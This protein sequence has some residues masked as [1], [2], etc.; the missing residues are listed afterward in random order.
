MTTGVGRRGFV[1]SAALGMAAALAGAPA[2]AENPPPAPLPGTQPP[3]E[4]AGTAEVTWRMTSSFPKSLDLMYGG[5]ETFARWVSALTDGKFRV[6]VSQAGEIVPGLQAL[7]AVQAG[8]VEACQTS[9]DYYFGK[10]P[11]FALATAFPFGLNARGQASF[12]HA[13]GGDVLFNTFLANYNVVA[14]PAGNT[15]AQM[16]GFVRKPLKS[17]ADVTGLKIRIGGLGG[18]VWQRLGAVPQATP[19]AELFGALDTAA[20]DAATWVS[21]Y[22][23]EKLGTDDRSALYKPAPNYYYPGWWRGGS[24]IHVAFNKT[25]YEALPKPFQAALRAAAEMAQADMLAA[26]DRQNPAALKRLVV[27]G[28]QLRAFP[29]DLLEAAYRATNDVLREIADGSPSFRT[30]LESLLSFRSEEY[31][32]WQ[33]GEYTFDNFMIRQRAKG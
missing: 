3:E 27:S 7:D 17:A 28:A 22:D 26:Y 13:G 23:D 24:A 8:T 4:S 2:H 14:F 20:L 30:F 21:P 29:Q 31:L 1:A 33:V 10:D 11:T 25:K 16:G 32:W 9:M 19:K 18:L 6:V 15:G 5:A 12:A